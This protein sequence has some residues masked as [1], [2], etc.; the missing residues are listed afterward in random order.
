MRTLHICV[1]AHL[2]LNAHARL[3]LFMLPLAAKSVAEPC[4]RTELQ[5]RSHMNDMCTHP[6]FFVPTQEHFHN[7]PVLHPGVCRWNHMRA[8]SNI[9]AH[10]SI[11]FR[12]VCQ[13]GLRLAAFEPQTSQMTLYSS[14]H[15]IDCK[16]ITL[17]NIQYMLRMAKELPQKCTVHNRVSGRLSAGSKVV[18]SVQ[19]DTSQQFLRVNSRGQEM[20]KIKFGEVWQ[21]WFKSASKMKINTSMAGRV[22]D[23]PFRQFNFTIS[24]Y[25]WPFTSPMNT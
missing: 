7:V 1:C 20:G 3:S 9:C 4:A 22:I 5:I 17:N 6:A 12:A 2:D 24:F 15:M 23:N 21:T 18:G 19:H 10:T 8:H 13:N 25:A 14:P 16:F 11:C